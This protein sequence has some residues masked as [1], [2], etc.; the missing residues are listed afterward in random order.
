MMVSR[1]RRKLGPYD[2]GRLRIQSVRSLGYL[3]V[4]P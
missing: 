4:L 2:D 1:V 3:Y